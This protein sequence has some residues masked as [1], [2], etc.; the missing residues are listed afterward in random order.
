M[1]RASDDIP[2]LSLVDPDGHPRI[3]KGQGDRF[4]EVPDPRNGYPHGEATAKAYFNV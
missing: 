2:D 3:I 1:E 4:F